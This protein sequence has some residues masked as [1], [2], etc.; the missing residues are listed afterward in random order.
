MENNC[1][2]AQTDDLPRQPSKKYST[3]A[4]VSRIVTCS[5]IHQGMDPDGLENGCSPQK[6]SPKK[7]INR[8]CLGE[9]S[10]DEP[11][12]S[13]NST[14]GQRQMGP[15]TRDRVLMSSPHGQAVRTSKLGTCHRLPCHV[16]LVHTSIPHGSHTHPWRVIADD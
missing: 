16:H 7:P 11:T 4:D 13:G 8:M 14:T 5:R 3:E 15:P 2:S 1:E 6:K 9:E 10:T 12:Q